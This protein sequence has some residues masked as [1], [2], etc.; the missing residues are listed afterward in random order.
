MY[1]PECS[2]YLR[3]R[4]VSLLL[5][6]GRESLGDAEIGELLAIQVCEIPTVKLSTLRGSR[7]AEMV[8][9][10]A[11]PRGSLSGSCEPV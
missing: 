3:L 5:Q 8:R 9:Q 10:I 2:Q 7:P 6:P 11:K 4:R 1:R